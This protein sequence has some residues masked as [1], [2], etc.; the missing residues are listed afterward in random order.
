[1]NL[2]IQN[3]FKKKF[4]SS[5]YLFFLGTISAFSLPPYNYFIINFITFTL[6]FIFLFNKKK[7]LIKIYFFLNMAGALV[8]DIF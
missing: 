3:F 5:I 4:S 1:M 8:L 2:L 6:F 7:K